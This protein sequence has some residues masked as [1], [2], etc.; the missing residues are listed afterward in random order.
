MAP[1]L[2]RRTANPATSPPKYLPFA[3]F[4]DAAILEADRD[5]EGGDPGPRE[6]S[7]DR[8]YER[9]G[10]RQT[11]HRGRA[12]GVETAMLGVTVG[13]FEVRETKDFDG[14]A[15]LLRKSIPEWPRRAH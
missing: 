6:D 11:L 7:L 2:P 10:W 12:G 9:R 13:G 5:H 1:E 4:A 14:W 15:N 8:Q 3:C